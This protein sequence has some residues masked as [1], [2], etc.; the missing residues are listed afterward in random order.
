MFR[1]AN[2]LQGG[3]AI[4]AGEYLIPARASTRDI[5]LMMTSGDALQHA[6]TF[7]EGITVAAA[8]R[9]IEESEV[10]TGE[11]PETPPEGSILPDTYH[12]QRGMTRAALVQQMRDAHDRVVAEVWARRAR[13]SSVTGSAGPPSWSSRGFRR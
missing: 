6:I 5:V 12:V 2:R 11:M 8:M 10:L 4:Q 13:H 3:G 9:I 7:P 1:I